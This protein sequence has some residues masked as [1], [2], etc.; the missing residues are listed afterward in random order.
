M[1]NHY[2]L[3]PSGKRTISNYFGGKDGT[4]IPWFASPRV[5]PSS[6]GIASPTQN[7]HTLVGCFVG[8]SS[9]NLTETYKINA[10]KIIDHYRCPLDI[11][12]RL[13]YLKLVPE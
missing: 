3:N 2:L 8:M 6:M 10:Q 12:L 5:V 1:A 13:T 9:S 7:G 11:L 4:K